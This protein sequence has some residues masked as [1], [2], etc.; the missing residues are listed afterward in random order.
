MDNP[1]RWPVQGSRLHKKEGCRASYGMKYA[2][3]D[4]PA[5]FKASMVARPD[6]EL[7]ETFAPSPTNWPPCPRGWK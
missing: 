1:P 7:L 2:T 5:T 6:R 4:T 3:Q